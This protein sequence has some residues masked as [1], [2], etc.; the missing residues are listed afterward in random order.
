M[1]TSG[2]DRKIKVWDLRKFE[3]MHEFRVPA[4]ANS[5]HYSSQG[6]L[7]AA[8]G[9]TVYVYRVSYHHGNTVYVY[10]VSYHHGNT[11]Y[12]YRVSQRFGIY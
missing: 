2:N 1:T 4:G 6:L 9:N 8:M 3:C 12:V 10:R 11:V 5:M 7:A